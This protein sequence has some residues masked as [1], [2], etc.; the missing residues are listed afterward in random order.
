MHRQTLAISKKVLGEEHPS[1]LKTMNNLALLLDSQGKYEE[2]ESMR[3]QTLATR[4]KVLGR[5]HLDTLPSVYYLAHL[6]ASR[7]RY[8]QYTA[9]YERAT[10]GN[11]PDEAAALAEIRALFQ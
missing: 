9:L 8:G 3:R 6:L 5:E 1:T 7:Y 11:Y 4:E 10:L 2:V